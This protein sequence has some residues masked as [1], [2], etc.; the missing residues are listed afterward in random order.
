[1]TEAEK[2][3][4]FFVIAVPEN[5]EQAKAYF[6]AR[7]ALQSTLTPPNEWV[8]VEDEI[9]SDD[10]DGLEFFCMTNATGKGGGV[11][12][13]EWEVATIRG[14]TVRRWKW[15]SRISPWAVT[16]WM[17]RP[18]PPGENNNV[19][20]KAPNEPLTLEQLR[21]MDETPIYVVTEAYGSG[22]CILNWHGVNKS[23]TYFSRTG[24]PEGMTATPLSA[25][26]YGDLWTAYRCP[27]EGGTT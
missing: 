15:R 13:L 19:S 14:K 2:A 21:E 24:T 12:P 16:H 4:Q 9:P 3:Y 26:T 20:T 7:K 25:K 1:M 23:Y 22:W 5:E 17:K 6:W 10:D 11:L 18:A 27:P 8:S